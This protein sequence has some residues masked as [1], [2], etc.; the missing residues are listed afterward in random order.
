VFSFQCEIIQIIGSFHTYK[1]WPTIEIACPNAAACM[2]TCSRQRHAQWTDILMN[3]RHSLARHWC[4][5]FSN[6][7]SVFPP[8]SAYGVS[9]HN[10]KLSVAVTA[11]FRR[12]HAKRRS[13]AVI[14]TS[15][16]RSKGRCID[17][18][19]PFEEMVENNTQR[20]DNIQVCRILHLYGSTQWRLSRLQKIFYRKDT[21]NEIR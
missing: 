11:I 16:A 20:R 7:F 13:I 15:Q 2:D 17:Y 8:C 4:V 9:G 6:S 3:N 10:V 12:L 14:V 21:R 5:A 1:L 19:F 18:M